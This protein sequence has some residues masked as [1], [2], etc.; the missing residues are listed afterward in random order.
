MRESLAAVAVI[1]RRQDGKTLWLAQWNRH[2]ARYHFVAGH[3]RADESFRECLVREVAEELL[4]RQGVDYVVPA[5]P[6]AHLEY[7][8]WSQSA[9]TETAYTMELFEVELAGKAA[10]AKLDADAKNRWLTH[11]E[12]RALRCEDGRPVSE[13]MPLLLQKAGLWR[14]GGEPSRPDHVGEADERPEE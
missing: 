4:L 9:Q 2:W 11:A 10:V 8:A 12:I 6:L 5:E 14:E 1:R 3:K 7:S 13:T